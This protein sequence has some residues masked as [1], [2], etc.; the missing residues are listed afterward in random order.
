MRY[1][2][3]W[4][5]IPHLAVEY[6]DQDFL[7]KVG[8]KIGK[9]LRID[10]NT[11]SA[12]RGQFTRLSVELDL[13]KPLL[14][15]FWLKGKV[16]KIQYEGLRMICF[17]CGKIGHSDDKCIAVK[18]ATDND[19][20]TT[21]PNAQGINTEHPHLIE[22]QDFGSWMM[23]KKPPPRKRPPRPE[24]QP[25]S[26]RSATKPPN[27]GQPKNAQNQAGNLGGS[28]FTVLGEQGQQTNRDFREHNI[29]PKDMG[30]EEI[31]NSFGTV[32]LGKDS[33]VPNEGLTPNPFNLGISSNRIINHTPTKTWQQKKKHN[34]PN[35]E[36][37]KGLRDITNI[38][39]TQLPQNPVLFAAEKENLP[40]QF[41]ATPQANT[42]TTYL[43]QT[44]A[45]NPSL[46]PKITTLKP[47]LSP[48]K[49]HQT[50]PPSL[51]VSHV[52]PPPQPNPVAHPTGEDYM[53]ELSDDQPI[54]GH[55]RPPD[56]H[57]GIR[58][59]FMAS[60]ESTKP[61]DDGNTETAI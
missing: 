8:G 59:T 38:P 49:H 40:I 17:S 20:H 31:T 18:D 5:R 10:H 15:K 3:A 42:A 37:N 58:D 1:L 24:K 61:G 14:S 34:I 9:V 51:E 27:H 35:L 54:Y 41:Q 32:D 43:P 11:A 6:F 12:D 44:Q 33:Q 48:D 26:N 30:T 45:I 47:S 60:T 22:D 21:E 28:R 55:S 53:C 36:S 57:D 39:T 23:V 4:V 52:S 56:E 19:M 29:P 50:N 46:N 25:E 2:T 16:W 7:K 13:A